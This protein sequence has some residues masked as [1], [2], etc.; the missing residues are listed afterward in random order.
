MQ[1]PEGKFET[2]T[3]L[4]NALGAQVGFRAN[5]GSGDALNE[6]VDTGATATWPPN[7]KHH[8]PE[9]W[10]KE[11]E[12]TLPPALKSGCT[13]LYKP[14]RDVASIRALAD[15]VAS[16]IQLTMSCHHLKVR[17]SQI[18]EETVLPNST[19]ESCACQLQ[20]FDLPVNAEGLSTFVKASRMKAL[21]QS[22]WEKVQHEVK[23]F[24]TATDVKRS[25]K[26]MM[27][28]AATNARLERPN[29]EIHRESHYVSNK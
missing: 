26:Q 5:G 1:L 4:T 21:E 11:L 15:G 27:A 22:L 28:Q 25:L 9:N 6:A 20:E 8:K 14:V 19:P 17:V 29:H 3:D 12:K 10:K 7:T 13:Q 23:L 16:K 18:H 24:E 2:I